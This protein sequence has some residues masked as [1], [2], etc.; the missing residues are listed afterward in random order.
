VSVVV[1]IVSLFIPPLQLS[2]VFEQM[3]N[4]FT[5][6]TVFVLVEIGVF[7][8]VGVEVGVFADSARSP[9]TSSFSASK[10]SIKSTTPAVAVAVAV[11]NALG[12]GTVV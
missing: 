7:D 8:K 2:A 6:S 10:H 11:G 9:K 5:K 4:L 12:E 3:S 1:S